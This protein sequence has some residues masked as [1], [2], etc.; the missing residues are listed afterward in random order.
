[1]QTSVD[2]F[3]SAVLI[4]HPRGEYVM[5]I[6]GKAVTTAVVGK[7]EI[8]LPDEEIK[9]IWSHNG[10]IESF[11]G[12]N[13]GKN[14]EE[15]LKGTFGC[16]KGFDEDSKKSI[17]SE[18]FFMKELALK[19]LAPP[20][21]SLVFFRMMISNFP[22]GIEYCDIYGCYG[23]RMRNAENLKPGKFTFDKYLE[24]I[25]GVEVSDG[26]KGDILK[27]NNVVNGY[28]IDVRRSLWD[29]PEYV[30][31]EDTSLLDVSNIDGENLKQEIK[32]LTQFPHKGR[33]QNYQTY[34]M[35]DKYEEGS[36][37][38]L[39]RYETMGLN[40]LDF[41]GK[42]VLDL[43][44]N[45]GAMLFEVKRRGAAKTLGIDYEG[46]YITCARRLAFY[47]KIPINFIK[48]DLNDMESI[49]HIRQYFCDVPIDIVFALSLY[50]HIHENVFTILKHL[51]WRV[52]YV[53][54]NNA[55]EGLATGHVMEMI[56][57]MSKLEAKSIYLG[58]TT[59]RSP[60]CIWR[61]EAT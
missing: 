18:F 32:D 13:K 43:G 52:C 22:Y 51:K 20:I 1:M 53:E 23:Y 49:K 41:N 16:D 58:Q 19:D 48:L 12:W 42:S 11:R 35:D 55:P 40:S 30:K 37:N 38:T 4:N 45:L 50:K 3:E 29:M 33:K 21:G 28:L 14:R 15:I 7:H 47:N 2:I 31:I 27:S 59:D 61:L 54:S 39:Y 24:A 60:R 26:A 17:L 10:K 36:R 34:Y 46:D 57:E 44:C 25:E 5:V 6:D 56:A 8:W 9:L